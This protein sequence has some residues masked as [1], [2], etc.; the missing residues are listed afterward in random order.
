MI[1]CGAVYHYED[2]GH[3]ESWPVSCG[4]LDTIRSLAEHFREHRPD[5]ELLRIEIEIHAEKGG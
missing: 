5:N 1:D 2:N 3:S 4:D